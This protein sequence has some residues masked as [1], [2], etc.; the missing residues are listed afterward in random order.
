[1]YIYLHA[2]AVQVVVKRLKKKED[3]NDVA[4][5]RSTHVYLCI[6]VYTHMSSSSHG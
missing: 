1:M 3:L 5:P 2:W 6:C 4:D